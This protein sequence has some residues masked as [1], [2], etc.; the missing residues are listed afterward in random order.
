MTEEEKARHD[1]Y[2]QRLLKALRDLESSSHSDQAR[3]LFNVYNEGW[4]NK[5]SGYTCGSCVQRVLGNVRGHLR[6]KG[7]IA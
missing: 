2:D 4:P 3:V 6:E 1:A 5:E 7:L